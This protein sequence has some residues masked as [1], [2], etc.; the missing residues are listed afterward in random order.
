MNAK[1]MTKTQLIEQVADLQQQVTEM[2]SV[3]GAYKQID[4][5]LQTSEKKYHQ[6][7]ETLQEGIWV[8]DENNL[9]SYVNPYLAQMLGYTEEEILEKPLFSFMDKAG[10]AIFEYQLD[11]S[12]HGFKEKHDFD[13]ICKDGS[14]MHTSLGTSPLFDEADNY[15]GSAAIVTDITEY[16][17][18]EKVLKETEKNYVLVVNTMQEAMLVVDAKG[19]VL[20]ANNK[21]AYDLSGGKPSDIIG[22]NIRETVPKTQAKKLMAVYNDVIISGQLFTRDECVSTKS[23][24]RWF[25]NVIH[26]L[27]YGPERVPAVLSMSIDITER[28]QAEEALQESEEKLRTIFE[29]VNDE[30]IFLD[31]QGIV[32]DVNGRVEDIFGYTPEEVIGK[33]FIDLNIFG[34]ETMQEV[35]TRFGEAVSTGVVDMMTLE[36][37]R[38]DGSSAYVEV[39]TGMI[40]SETGLK[41]FFVV[42][43]DI[44][45][46]KQAEEATLQFVHDLDERVKELNCHYGFD[47]LIETPG[48]TLDG[49]FEGTVKLI[50][51]SWQYPEVTCAR[52]TINNVEFKTANYADTEWKQTSDISIGEEKLGFVEVGYLEEMPEADEGTFLKEERWLLNAIAERLSRVIERKQAR[53]GFNLRPPRTEH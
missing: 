32:I 36:I 15:L 24:E 9:T 7:V 48:I 20:F 16:K 18:A 37:C 40:E 26:P 8:F 46:H 22:K 29:N 41:R 51:P 44:T 27:N 10:V 11:R 2:E 49:I 45:E 1:S 52:L 33:N 50:P 13:F 3:N 5:T 39:N 28:K 53:E 35:I 47:R 12:R 17:Q 42:V 21:S 4:D 25:H 31:E 14:S 19:A 34:P 6:L 38:K 43:R 23:G 30:I